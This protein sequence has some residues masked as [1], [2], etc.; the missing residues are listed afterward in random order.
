[1]G[2]EMNDRFIEN[3]YNDVAALINEYSHYNPDEGEKLLENLQSVHD[4]PEI[5]EA[6]FEE[7]KADVLRVITL[8]KTKPN[9]GEEEKVLLIDAQ[10]ILNDIEC[11]IEYISGKDRTKA[12]HTIKFNCDH[13]REFSTDTAYQNTIKLLE[14]KI[15]EL[16]KNRLGSRPGTVV[17]HSTMEILSSLY[18]Y[19]EV[20]D[21]LNKK[22]RETIQSLVYDIAQNINKQA[23]EY[24][25]HKEPSF[26]KQEKLYK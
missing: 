11:S 7:E 14:E 19:T 4:I 18:Y 23:C 24:L 9:L 17:F 12:H 3:S 8:L 1:M 6:I 21:D 25:I 26:A 5:G 20:M 10:A 2:C 13:L 15:H 22:D 16:F